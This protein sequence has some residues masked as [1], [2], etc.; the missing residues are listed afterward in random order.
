MTQPF[1]LSPS[2][3]YFAGRAAGHFQNRLYER[4]D[5]RCDAIVK[6]FLFTYAIA[7]SGVMLLPIIRPLHYWAMGKYPFEVWFI[8]YKV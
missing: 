2:I 3:I 1:I 4:A 7:V 5:K 6:M 8:S